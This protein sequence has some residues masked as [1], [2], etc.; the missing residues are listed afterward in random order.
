[1][2]NIYKSLII[3][4]TMK[5][6]FEE[7]DQAQKNLPD[8]LNEDIPEGTPIDKDTRQRIDKALTELAD[9][10]IK[11]EEGLAQGPEYPLFFRKIFSWGKRRLGRKIE[12]NGDRYSGKDTR[13]A[14]DNYIVALFRYA[15]AHDE[16]S[17]LRVKVKMDANHMQTYDPTDR[18]NWGWM[19]MNIL[20]SRLKSFDGSYDPEKVIKKYFD[21]SYCC[22]KFF[23]EK[24]ECSKHIIGLDRLKFKKPKNS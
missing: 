14:C 6:Q 24:F 11:M 22:Y 18:E 16:Q 3:N 12:R 19:Y 17:V 8:I 1:M 2:P 4:N 15:A 5:N 10:V 7:L 9:Q 23:V 21:E 13:L 20:D